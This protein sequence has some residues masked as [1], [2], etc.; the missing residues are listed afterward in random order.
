MAYIVSALIVGLCLYFILR[1]FFSKE[2]NLQTDAIV[3]D[4]EVLTLDQIYATLNE[5]EM[6]F[7]MGK[8]SEQNYKN[9]KSQYEYMA[10]EKL[11]EEAY[12]DEERNSGS[13]KEEK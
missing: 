3:D 12:A 11:K 2:A 13:K 5:L 8:L 6:E 4:L 9:L 1:P 7:H 10:A